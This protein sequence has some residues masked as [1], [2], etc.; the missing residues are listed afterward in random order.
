MKNTERMETNIQMLCFVS[1]LLLLLFPIFV[2][3]VE[4]FSIIFLFV[5]SNHRDLEFLVS[6][7]PVSPVSSIED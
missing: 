7:Q 5:V 1:S 6:I 3:Y 2:I 4:K